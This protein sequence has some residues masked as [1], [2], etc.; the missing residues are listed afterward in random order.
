[1]KKR[2][3]TVMRI[4]IAL[5]ALLVGVAFGRWIE[6]SLAADPE[7][8]T[9]NVSAPNESRTAEVLATPDPL[10]ENA[11]KPQGHKTLADIL[12][13]RKGRNRIA[14]LTAYVDHLSTGDF[15]AALLAT[16]KLAR[17]S[18]RELATQLLAARWAELDPDGA[19][20]FASSHK[21]FPDLT[22][23]V[24]Q[25]LAS[26]DLQSALARA[27][28]IGDSS[29]R[30]QALRG[31]LS[32]MAEQDPVGAL[33]LAGTYGDFP[34][35]EPLTQMI[36]RQWSST[37]PAAAAA[38][39]AQDSSSSGWRSP[40][41][42]V[43]R[44]WATDDPQGALNYAL[45]MS[46]PSTQAHSVGEIVR[47][48]G[49]QDPTAAASW[50]NTMSPGPARDAAAAALASAVS[51]TDLSAAVGWADSISDESLR[52]SALQR[53]GRR[54]LASD[55]TNGAATLTSAGFP[56]QIVQSLSTPHP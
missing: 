47:Q 30:Y 9:A 55:P 31:A 34:H 40:L 6:P 35:A 51:S 38:V 41:G 16:R 3:D 27:Q 45:T 56:P 54:V 48:W 4:A 44:T 1:M 46:D 8:A 33:Q 10:A 43:V 50:I 21:E 20:A 39:A 23:D 7:K 17:G 24:F 13:D 22:S 52:T 15:A 28:S 18:D 36:Y 11:T 37:D 19:L 2:S 14:E 49:N 12:K 32:V 5:S 53:V 42:Q 25:Q 26:G 29:M